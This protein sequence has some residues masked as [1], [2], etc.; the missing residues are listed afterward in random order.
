MKVY[1]RSGGIDPRTLDLGTRWRLVVSFMPL[2]LYPWGKSLWYLLDRRLGEPQSWSLDVVEF[3]SRTLFLRTGYTHEDEIGISRRTF[4][5]CI[6]VILR[7]E[8]KYM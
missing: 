2:P 1:W 3:V 4:K 5:R 8:E 7:R 6:L